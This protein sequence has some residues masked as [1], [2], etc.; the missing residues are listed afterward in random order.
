MNFGDEIN[1]TLQ[2]VQN[3]QRFQKELASRLPQLLGLPIDENGVIE[4]DGTSYKVLQS[5][6]QAPGYMLAVE[7]NVS[8]ST[9]NQVVAPTILF[10]PEIK[11]AVEE[12]AQN[13]I[14][15]LQKIT[16]LADDE[17]LPQDL[18]Q[19]LGMLGQIFSMME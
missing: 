19:E 6:D 8:D 1:Q 13:P 14:A 18:R 11:Q 7:A 12:L 4:V 5:Y 3:Q 2:E 9:E 17:T 15:F 10:V 16:A